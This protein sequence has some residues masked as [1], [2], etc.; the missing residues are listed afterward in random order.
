[1]DVAELERRMR[2][3]GWSEGG[4]LGHDERLADVLAADARTLEALARVEAVGVRHLPRPSTISSGKR[5]SRDHGPT[6]PLPDL[7]EVR[8]QERGRRAREIAA[9]GSHNL[10]LAGPPGTGKTMLARRMPSILPPLSHDEALADRSVRR[11]GLR[12]ARCTR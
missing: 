9:A 3:G 2:P 6:R 7:A 11:A 4:F 8:G 5:T 12:R 1:M 10:L